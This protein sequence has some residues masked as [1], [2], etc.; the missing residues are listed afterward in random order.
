MAKETERKQQEPVKAK[1]KMT[2]F[3]PVQLPQSIEAKIIEGKPIGKRTRRP[4]NTR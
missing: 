3:A 4:R 1:F 2:Q